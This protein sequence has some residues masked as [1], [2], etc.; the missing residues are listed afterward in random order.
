MSQL[1]HRNP[2]TADP[3]HCNID[4]VQEKE[5]KLHFMNMIKILRRK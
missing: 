3:E 1:E 2:T 5:L 4:E